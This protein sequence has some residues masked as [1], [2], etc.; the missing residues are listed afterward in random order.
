MFLIF[1]AELQCMR[2]KKTKKRRRDCTIVG[3]LCPRENLA[4]SRSHTRLKPKEKRPEGGA[5]P[6][7]YKAQ[8]FQ[9][10]ERWRHL[11]LAW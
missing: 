1:A 11:K 7:C 9:S 3:C 6:D 2:K 8:L 10:S 5:E 4:K